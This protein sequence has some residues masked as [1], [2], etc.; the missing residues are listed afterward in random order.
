M[1][2]AII[3]SSKRSNDA[4]DLGTTGVIA[5]I[6]ILSPP[7]WHRHHCSTLL[8]TE[9]SHPLVDLF[10]VMIQLLL[11]SVAYPLVALVTYVAFDLAKK[12]VEY[13]TDPL[14]N[15]KLGPSDGSFL[16]GLFW[17]IRKEPFMEPH[18]RIINTVTGWNV[19]FLHYTLL[20]GRPNLL[21]LD[22]AIVRE[23][24]SA[25]YGKHPLRFVKDIKFLQTVLGDGLVTLQGGDWMRH[26][27]IIQ[28]AFVAQSIRETLSG[29]VP[30]LTRR[31]GGHWKQAEGREIDVSSHLASLT[32]EVIGH[33]AFSHEF[34]ALDGVRRWAESSAS[35]RDGDQLAEIDDPFIRAFADSFAFTTISTVAFI[36][37]M[38]S[39]N[40]WFNPNTKNVRRTLN[41][42]V[43]SVIENAKAA[44]QQ[45]VREGAKE[46]KA[47]DNENVWPHDDRGGAG[48]N[49]KRYKSLLQLLLEAHEGESKKTLDDLELRDEVKTFI[50]AGH[51]TT[52]TWCYNAIFALT[53]YPDIQERV[54]QDVLKHA[55]S[56]PTK[57]LDLETVEQMEYF[58]A[59]LQEVL[60][61]FPPI[62]MFTRTT[63]V[64]GE[65]FGTPYTIRK[66][67]R[68]II[69]VY[70]LHRHPSYWKN[71]D[72]FQPE[73][74]IFDNEKARDAFMA[75]IR[76]AF[77][78]FSAGG[79]NCIGQKFATHEAKLI[80]A[81]LIRTFSIQVAPSQ[82]DVK[83]TMSN[84]IA[85]R[86]K[87]RLKIVVKAR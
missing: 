23:I 10:I 62:G 40:L 55:P 17:V 54:F 87:P 18:L 37:G 71:P 9:L 57:D 12:Y 30:P 28:P 46:K 58:N 8:S 65:T 20:F 83:F 60:R 45:H 53:Q 33:A 44:M 86:T 29:L 70:V 43:D 1:Q 26:R 47:E 36:L 32:L 39:I 50:F 64:D 79:R 59:F 85:M 15:Q 49:T 38:P 5:L 41:A 76:F 11:S 68:V 2:M 14:R 4:V 77:L 7:P 69:P 6:K 13:K 84:V 63:N 3:I 48:K 82:R 66:G 80:M 73:R 56:D 34:H 52:S 67:T 31:L 19:P 21:I 72:T 22:K 74:W 42:G 27:S 25:P 75:E 16:W 24:L 61:M 78:P 81:E 35:E 51:E